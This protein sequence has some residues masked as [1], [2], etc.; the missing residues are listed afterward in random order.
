S[1]LRT[2]LSFPSGRFF[3]PKAPEAAGKHDADE[4]CY[5][6]SRVVA[7]NEPMIAVVGAG[8]MGTALAVVHHRASVATT[9][10]GTR[11]DGAAI[12]ACRTGQPHPAL[13]VPVPSGVECRPHDSW[14]AALRN[15]ERIVIAVSS[16]GLADMI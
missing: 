10:L 2:S 16:D 6:P 13:G 8:A 5:L 1:R 4:Q 15:A 3:A 14:A 9:L 7:R 12:E 11:F